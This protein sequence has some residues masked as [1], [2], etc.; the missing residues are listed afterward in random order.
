MHM[1]EAK[2]LTKKFSS[3]GRLSNGQS[4]FTAVDDLSF[5]LAEGEI[6][7][8]LGPNGAGKTTTIQ[9]LLGVLTPTSGEVLYFGKNLQKHRSEILEDVNF[10]STYTN[11]PWWLTVKENLTYI[12]Y[13][14]N[15]KN[16]K[17]RL[18]KIV[19]IFRLED[20]Y[21]QKMESLSA[22]QLTRVNLAKAFVNLPKV[23]LLDEPTASLDVEIAKYIHEFLLEER[24]NFNT[25]II[26]TS[27][28]MGEVEELCDR[29]I[30]V[31]HGKIIAN[32]TPDTLAKTIK[33]SHID[34]FIR[35]GLKKI[36]EYCQHEKLQYVIEGKHII[37]DVETVEIPNFLRKLSSLHVH[38]DEISIEEPSLED[39]FLQM[40][41]KTK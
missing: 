37:I 26:I 32:D 3:K 40:V 11:L 33:T 10:S 28:N 20:I 22:G 1:L 4:N 29:V 13:L 21:M 23:L 27:H 12:S 36:E 31:N 39:Y 9:M 19:E 25:S 15:I 30:V 8:F 35:N 17:E 14:F 5:Y 18:K 34:L 6:L 24:K 7:G 2:K 41:R 38:Y 16:R